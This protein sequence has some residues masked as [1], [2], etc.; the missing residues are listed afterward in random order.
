MTFQREDYL[1][2]NP[3]QNQSN[4]TSE[5]HRG[6]NS[7]Y[8]D[9]LE[10]YKS[11]GKTETTLRRQL[12]D[13][14]E[15]LKQ[16]FQK[17]AGVHQDSHRAGDL[18]GA[19]YKLM[20]LSMK[21]ENLD[22]GEIRDALA[23]FTHEVDRYEDNDLKSR[24][25]ELIND[26]ERKRDA[27]WTA[28][29]SGKYDFQKDREEP[30]RQKAYDHDNENAWGVRDIDRERVQAGKAD[31]WEREQERIRR[32]KIDKEDRI[33]KDREEMDK[34]REEKRKIDQERRDNERRLGEEKAKKDRE[35]R[36]RRDREED[37]RRERAREE[38]EKR[39]RED[40]EDRER[41]QK[42]DDAKK[43]RDREEQER[44]AEDRRKREHEEDDRRRREEDDRRKMEDEQR[45]VKKKEQDERDKKNR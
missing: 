30:Q 39:D 27:E 41:R 16:T 44:L 14:V 8:E 12:E 5:R 1:Q 25:K 26:L 22:K 13:N 31:E 37:S 36:E 18:L 4:Y 28:A 40:R 21:G 2:K 34:E 42:E 23:K 15:E 43:K 24:Q 45:E 19:S 6:P 7:A 35:E 33:K 17:Q 11:G 32:D 10:S 20:E 3:E 9:V 38:K 29:K